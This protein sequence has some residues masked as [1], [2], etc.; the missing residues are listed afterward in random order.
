MPKK[1]SREAVLAALDELE[2]LH[3]ALERF[4][5]AQKSDLLEALGWKR[6]PGLP[7]PAARG[8]PTPETA[9]RTESL[10]LHTDGASRGNP[11]PASIGVVISDE[12][13]KLLDELAE[14]IGVRTNN[15][16]EYAAVIRGLERALEL[17][18]KH[19]HV[20]AD[21]QLVIRQ[22]EGVYKVK[23]E[24]IQPLFKMAKYLESKFERGVSYEHVRREENTEADALANLALDRG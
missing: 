3:R 5:G 24:G 12:S 20:R 23:N 8:L 1:L 10:V 13:G 2:P 17:G 7:P 6:V 9:A 4:P 21:S 16:A 11:G 15:Y 18:A 14:K 22:L 19:V